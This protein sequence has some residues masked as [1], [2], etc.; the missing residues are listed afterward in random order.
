MSK[1]TFFTGQPI[2]NQLLYLIPRE[3]VSRLVRELD[4]DRYYK[5]FKT[6]DHLVTML[7]T[8]FYGC[9]SLREVTT[10]MMV[11]HNK[12]Q[13]LGL[14]YIPRR[15]TLADANACR[16]EDFFA[17][18]YHKL[19]QRY[20]GD[21]PDSRL[22]GGIERHLFIMDSTTIKLFSDIMKGAGAKPA[23]GKSKGG[24]KAHVLMKADEEVPRLVC[25]SHASK[26]DRLLMHKFTLPAGSIIVFDKG[27]I[28][29]DK[30]TEWHQQ[31]IM[32][33]GRLGN[34]ASLRVDER[35]EV[36]PQ[37]ASHGIQ[38]DEII[39][40]GRPSNHKNMPIA[41]RK[42]CLY[43]AATKKELTF[44]TNN[45]EVE[46]EMIADIYKRRWQIELLFKRIKQSYP[47]R[48]FLGDNENAIK[49]QIWCALIADLLVKIIKDGIRRKWSY[50]N[51][52]SMIRLHLM[53]YVNLI[54]FL[55]NPDMAL[56]LYDQRENQQ[57]LGLFT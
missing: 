16:S 44:I 29:Y 3:G 9:K 36:N 7:F 53:T 2:F 38:S 47:L 32:W 21:L 22:P 28:N 35:R 41:V 12:L 17:R 1:S 45:T 18:L 10:G 51:I 39:T 26:N 54:E 25:I 23:N 14:H 50:A 34:A 8:S 20:Y 4:T 40:L 43:D 46:P 27:Y 24:A 52:S 49:I 33:V 5:K 15:S 31:G 42:I 56:R 37:S 30:Y 11:V 6:Y 55:N 48:Y 13:H 19:Y 57:Q